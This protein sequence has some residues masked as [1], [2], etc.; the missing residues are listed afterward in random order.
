MGWLNAAKP[1][2]SGRDLVES[3]H[4]IQRAG[5]QVQGGFIVGFD[6]DTPKIFQQQIDFIQK[7]GIVTAMVG[8]LQA[9]YETPLYKRLMEEGRL[10]HGMSGDNMDGST[11][12]IPRMG[13][14]KLKTGY[15]NILD[16]IYSPRL[17]YERVHTFLKE[18]HPP[19][20]TSPLEFE[21]VA[22]FFR[23]VYLLGIRGKERL[24][25]W[26][27]ILWTLFHKPRVLPPGSHPGHHRL[28]FPQSV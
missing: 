21:Y 10:L 23:S 7:S 8:L 14:E 16:H 12:I 5:M 22:A 18:Y 1:K 15:R 27:L 2:T 11:N 20:I 19:K 13:I 4:R 26:R 17:Y 6:S 9:P 25:Y 3:V 28:P 24:Q